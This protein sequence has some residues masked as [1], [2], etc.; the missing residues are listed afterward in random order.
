M[1]S[2]VTL[3]GMPGAGKSTTGIILAKYLSCGFLDTDV[4]IQVHRKKS[5]QEIIDESG[6]LILR[7]FEE[8]EILGINVKNYVIATGGSAVYSSKAMSYLQ[9]IST[10]I[11]LTVDFEVILHRIH[12][13][14]IRGI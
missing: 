14:D 13:F 10:I 12:N 8:E 9:E 7:K 1:K 11:F 5:L 4:L 6:Y 2:N 3:I